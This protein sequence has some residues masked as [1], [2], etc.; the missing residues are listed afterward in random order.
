MGKRG[1]LGAAA[2]GTALVGF[3]LLRNRVRRF[4]ITE[5][6]MTPTLHT[7]DFVLASRLDSAP[8]RGDIV[9][10]PHPN[11]PSLLMVKRV[12]GLPTE[13]VTVGGGQVAANDHVVA[14]PWAQGS[15]AGDFHWSLDSRHVI[16]LSDNRSLPTEDSRDLGPVPLTDVWRVGFRYWPLARVGGVR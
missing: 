8:M 12:V 2:L 13:T 7:N 15:L 6:S 11:K 16:V 1:A 10:F 5:A 3:G 9:I 14:E 4:E